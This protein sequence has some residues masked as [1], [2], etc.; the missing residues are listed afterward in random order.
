MKT[1]IFT[2]K[3]IGLNHDVL[4]RIADK[5]ESFNQLIRDGKAIAPELTRNFVTF[6]LS[7]DSKG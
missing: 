1:V 2:Q 6:P 7:N 4:K 5:Y 3:G